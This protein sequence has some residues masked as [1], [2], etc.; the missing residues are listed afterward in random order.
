[1]KTSKNR[2][3]M[4]AAAF[5]TLLCAVMAP[6]LADKP[7]ELSFPPAVFVDFDP[8]TGEFHEITIFFDVFLHEGHKNN[9]VGR[10]VR[11]G[12]TDSGYELFAG[13]EIQVD[14]GN[15]FISKF[16]DMWR[17]DDGRMFVASGRFIFN[18]NQEEVKVDSFVFRCIG[19]ETI[20]PS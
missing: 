9:F 6:V 16:K 8:C 10:A 11:T 17:N 7:T 12:F 3:P 2:L 20:F 4:L 13:N 14:N 19:G 1:M 15:V 18:I 5:A